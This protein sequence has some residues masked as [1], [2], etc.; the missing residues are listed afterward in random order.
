MSHA[1]KVVAIVEDEAAVRRS[2]ERLLRARGIES[3]SFADGEKF[4][5]YLGVCRPNCVILGHPAKKGG[6]METLLRIT[7]EALHIPIL[8]LTGR[9]LARSRKRGRLA[10]VE[11]F[12]ASRTRARRASRNGQKHRE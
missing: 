3:E 10:L 4:L 12:P 1:R 6:A 7:A 11:R 5:R 2:L 8:V 9:R